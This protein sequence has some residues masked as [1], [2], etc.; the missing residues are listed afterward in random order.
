[1]RDTNSPVITESRN[2]SDLLQTKVCMMGI[3]GTQLFSGLTEREM[4]QM[5]SDPFHFNENG[6]KYFTPLITP[7]LIK[8]YES[9]PQH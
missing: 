3:P 7:A 1:M 2:W 5:Y 8:F 4:E 9:H 6:Q